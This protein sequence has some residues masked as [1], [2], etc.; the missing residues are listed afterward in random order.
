MHPPPFRL[1]HRLSDWPDCIL[2]MRCEPCASRSSSFP[3]K[4]LIA[5]HGDGTFVQVLRRPRCGV[6]KRR[7]G[8]VYLCAGHREFL[9]GPP[10][11]W[12]IELVPVPRPGRSGFV[13]GTGPETA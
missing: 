13:A 1:D 11:A 5:R 4:L 3:V 9:G 10:A 8:P 2:E 7:P 12:A 6:C